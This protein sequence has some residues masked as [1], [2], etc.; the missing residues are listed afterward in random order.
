MVINSNLTK[1]GVSWTNPIAFLKKKLW[2][3]ERRSDDSDEERGPGLEHFCFGFIMFFM[4]QSTMRGCC[5]T[6]V[7]FVDFW[8]K[9]CETSRL[10]PLSTNLATL[11]K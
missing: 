11:T 4:L 9:V 6:S 5:F 2:E 8:I 7:L 3:H 1:F 10:L